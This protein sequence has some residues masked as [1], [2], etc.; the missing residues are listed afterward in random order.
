M[1][2]TINAVLSSKKHACLFQKQIVLIEGNK[3]A[4]WSLVDQ[5]AAAH[6]LSQLKPDL[7]L[8]L[9]QQQ[10]PEYLN[11][12]LEDPLPDSETSEPDLPLHPEPVKETLPPSSPPRS[13]SPPPTENS[14]DAAEEEPKDAHLPDSHL[15]EQTLESPEHRAE[16]MEEE[17][18]DSSDAEELE[19][20]LEDL[21][22]DLEATYSRR[23]PEKQRRR[24]ES[25]LE[26]EEDSMDEGDSSS[27]Y[28]Q[29]IE[30]ALAALGGRGTGVEITT[31]IDDHYRDILSNKTKTWRNSVMGCLSANRRNL[32]AKEPVKQNA[33]RYVWKLNDHPSRPHHDPPSLPVDD[34][35]PPLSFAPS[36][37]SEDKR[38]KKRRSLSQS[39]ASSSSLSSPGLSSMSSIELK[40]RSPEQVSKAE[41][42]PVIEEVNLGI[43]PTVRGSCDAAEAVME[44]QDDERDTHKDNDK[45]MAFDDLSTPELKSKKARTD[46]TDNENYVELIEQAMRGLGGKATGQDITE[47]ISQTHQELGHNKKKLG[48]RVNAVLSSKKYKTIFAKDTT[49]EGRTVWKLTNYSPPTTKKNRN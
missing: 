39:Q 2:Y 17:D 43:P 14:F 47:S 36:V 49:F 33:K 26:E 35:S 27:T 23:S 38:P 7:N 45:E 31:Y 48:Y 6:F 32:F 18:S 1:G 44:Q 20:E 42:P 34:A 22:D 24:R 29:M 5:E 37:A 16:E 8:L 15:Q 10:P 30:Q 46:A 41:S 11:P 25:V 12:S 9:S 4:L 21:E 40:S 13:L 28:T 19:L 3:R